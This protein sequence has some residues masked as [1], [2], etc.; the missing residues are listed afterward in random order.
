[1]VRLGRKRSDE[2]YAKFTSFPQDDVDKGLYANDTV[3]TLS[4]VGAPL[5]ALV[6]C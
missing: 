1:M 3:G 2:L 4:L 6:C 5:P